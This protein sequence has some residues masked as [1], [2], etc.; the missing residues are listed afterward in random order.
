M[1]T[2][3]L[4]SV[5]SLALGYRK[6][7]ILSFQDFSLDS[8]LLKA[9]DACGFEQPSDI[10]QQ[11]I[12]LVIQGR[13]LMA[14]APTGTGKTAAFVLPVLQRLLD[15]K[16][17][18]GTGPRVLVLTPTRELAKQ[19]EDN[20]YKLTRFARMNSCSIVGG[21]PYPPQIR[22]LK[23]RLDFLVATPGRLMDHIQAGR[24][25]FSRTNTLILDEADRM[26]DMGFIEE[27]NHIASLLPVQRQTLLFSATLEGE[28]EKVAR[29][30]LKDP[31]RV[32]V[33]SVQVKHDAIT[34][35]LMQADD[36]RHKRALLAHV[37]DQDD[38]RQVIIFTATKR[39]A[40]DLAEKLEADGHACGALHGDMRQGMRRRTV[41]SLRRGKLKVLV[42]TDVAAR[43]LDIRGITHVVNF[44]MPM[45]AEDYVHRIGRTGRG[46]A[47]GTAISIVGPQ[48]RMQLSR[49]EKLLGTRLKF[50]EIPGLE[51]KLPKMQ[52]Q[53]RGNPSGAGKQP[54]IRYRKR[55]SQSGT[56]NR[57][58]RQNTASMA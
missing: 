22:N 51:P 5:L 7:G 18:K 36:Y 46:G 47:T 29:K 58:R 15:D 19:V 17:G 26:L 2:C 34:Q 42:A 9:V 44:D 53:R 40:E 27:V 55:A 25:D 23:Q 45:Q 16:P 6:G 37:L 54:N 28:I 39:G 8:R 21:M 38:V 52:E 11:A 10:Q 13:D 56:G 32:Q 57:Q 35:K 41:E 4:P 43:G 14:S 20:I 49:I 48:D 1:A 24:V 30:L 3:Y 12:P 33:A 50:C 31:A